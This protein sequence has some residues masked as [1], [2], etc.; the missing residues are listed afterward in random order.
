MWEVL[1]RIYK[2]VMVHR[3][4]NQALF[5][6]MIGLELPTA[7][8][9]AMEDQ[10]FYAAA[11]T[12]R[13]IDR[14]RDILGR[15]YKRV[16]MHRFTNQALIAVMIGLELPTAQLGAMEDQVFYAA[17]KT[18]RSIDHMWEVLGRM[19]KRVMMHRFTNQAL[20]AVMIGLELPTA[21]LAAIEGQRGLLHCSK[22]PTKHLPH[23]GGPR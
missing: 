23:V 5:A 21:Q 18:P 7:Q 13:A 19:Y 16:M 22:D 20:F 17:A 6:V 14:M 3:F 2:R 10:V 8:L 4:T 11:K 15:M 9:G 1:G 12:P